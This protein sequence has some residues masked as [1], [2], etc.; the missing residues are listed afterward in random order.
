MA[1]LKTI[2][3]IAGALVAFALVVIIILTAIVL[4]IPFIA[5]V[6]LFFLVYMYIR[7]KLKK[8]NNEFPAKSKV[9][10]TKD[11]TVK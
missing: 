7:R 8:S 3:I 6:V 5:L 4:L 9:I 10:S 11:Y 1:R 2:L